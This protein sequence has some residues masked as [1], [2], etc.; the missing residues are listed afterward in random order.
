M[1]VEEIGNAAG[2]GNAT[3]DEI[4]GRE[5]EAR[6]TRIVSQ[7]EAKKIAV[8]ADAGEVP[9]EIQIPV[10]IGG[11]E[12]EAARVDGAAKKMIAGHL[13]EI[14]SIG[15]FQDARVVM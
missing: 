2:E 5:I 15:R 7:A 13:D 9:G 3:T 4:T 10:A 11:V 8:S 14:E 6:V 1:L 12:D